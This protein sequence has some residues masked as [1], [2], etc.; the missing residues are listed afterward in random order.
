MK[1]KYFIHTFGCQQN[2]ADSERIAAYCEAAGMEKAHSLEGAN[3]VV[4]TT[5]MIRESAENRVYGMV[6]NLI[7]LK[8]KK[9]Q[10]NEE[11]T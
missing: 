9:L 11:F 6:H 4:V 2:I 5:C 3:Y 1:R 8:Q 10:S 7:P